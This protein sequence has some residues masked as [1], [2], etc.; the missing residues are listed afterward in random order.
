MDDL[1][2][3]EKVDRETLE[4]WGGSNIRNSFCFRDPVYV[5][6]DFSRCTGRT[7]G[8]FRTIAHLVI[9]IFICGTRN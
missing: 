1:R 9:Y 7:G 6:F 8:L 2:H 5:V 4:Y 3:G